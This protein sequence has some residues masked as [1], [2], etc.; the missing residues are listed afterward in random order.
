M[1]TLMNLKFILS[2]SIILLCLLISLASSLGYFGPKIKNYFKTNSFIEFILLIFITYSIISL[3]IHIVLTMANYCF[4]DIQIDYLFVGE[5]QQPINNTNNPQ[6]PVR[7]WPSGTTQTW[8]ILGS[9][10]AVYRGLPAG[11]GHRHRAALALTSLGITIP[12]LVFFH[13]VENPEGFNRLMYSWTHYLR[14][15]TWPEN[16][17]T[18]VSSNQSELMNNITPN[19]VDQAERAINNNQAGN[20]FLPKD[21]D[22]NT[23][24][25]NFIQSDF[26][27]MVIGVFRPVAVE[28][29]LDDLLGLELFIHLLMVL[30]V[31]SLI[32]FLISFMIL[33]ILLH[34]KEFLMKRFNSKNKFISFYIKYQFILLKLSTIVLP[35]FILFGLV[36][37]LVGLHYLL[38]HPIPYEQL[39]I[40]LHTYIKKD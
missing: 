13:A 31:L 9:A 4:M 40:D 27:K 14:H 17:P 2:V 6:D 36:E 32:I 37:L 28:G 25:E 10:L 20:T 7:W 30:I 26:A 16:I 12:S 24:F 22:I 19:L 11:I 3:L 39:P 1:M 38:T 35:L 15:N 21:I 23:L 29:H 18:N 8:T 33:N 5:N 34:N